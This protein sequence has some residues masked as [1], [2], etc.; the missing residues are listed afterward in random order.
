MFS[1]RVVRAQT[2]GPGPPYKVGGC[3]GAEG[4]CAGV[5]GVFVKAVVGRVSPSAV[6]VVFNGVKV[7][8]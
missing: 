8:D 3:G 2:G 4:V 5:K 6:G 7:V 1:E